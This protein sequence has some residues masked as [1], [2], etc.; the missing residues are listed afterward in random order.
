MQPAQCIVVAINL[1]LE[2]A[3]SFDAERRASALLHPAAVTPF[4]TRT[5]RAVRCAVCIEQIPRIVVRVAEIIATGEIV[6]PDVGGFRSGRNR[7]KIHARK[8]VGPVI[9]SLPDQ[10][11]ACG[12]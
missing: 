2:P 1:R 11:A 12:V 5:V 7:V 6:G 3:R 4:A 9:G 10:R 8:E